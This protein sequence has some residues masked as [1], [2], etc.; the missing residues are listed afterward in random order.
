MPEPFVA[1]PGSS[2][3]ADSVDRVE[4][5]NALRGLWSLPDAGGQCDRADVTCTS[6][7]GMIEA[8]P[9]AIPTVDVETAL[10]D[11][12]RR[13]TKRFEGEVP[14]DIVAATVRRCANRWAGARVA[15]FIPLLTE[16]HCIEQLRVAIAAADGRSP[17]WSTDRAR[18]TLVVSS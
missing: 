15:E 7:V 13:L 2:D 4:G 16:R 18:V 14:P 9:R 10:A 11:V 17:D 5:H 6:N 3:A 12:T 8:G 1:T